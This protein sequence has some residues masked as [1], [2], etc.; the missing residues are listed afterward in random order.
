MASEENGSVLMIQANPTDAE[1]IGTF[2]EKVAGYQVT[3]AL[4]GPDFIRKL[5]I[6][7]SMI[8]IDTQ[9]NENFLRAIEI[10]RRIPKLKS[11]PIGVVTADPSRLARCDEKGIN[12]IILK[13]FTP[14]LLLAKIWKL[15]KLAPPPE[16]DNGKKGGDLNIQVDQIENLPTLPSVY[17]EVERLCQNPDVDSEELSKV[18]QTDPSITLKLLRLANSAFFGF[19]RKVNSVK[20]AISLLGN[21][22][23]K[24][25]VLSISIYEAT[26]GEEVSAGLDKKKFWQHS[27]G[28][29][30]IA[31]F[32]AN[33][34]GIQR[35]EVFAA[36]I[37]HDIGKVVLDGLFSD[38]YAPVLKAV[39]E[40]KISI[41]QAEQEE[42]GLPHTKIGQELG[43][44]WKIPE[45][46]IEGISHHHKPGGSDF[47][48]ELASLIH[49]ADILCRNAEMGSGGDDLVPLIDEFASEKLSVGPEKILEW[50][51]D[52][53]SELEKDR[54]FLSA[55]EDKKLN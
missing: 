6:S 17:S 19:T 12:G 48:P 26:K 8:L 9:M 54:T 24:N 47:D 23:V 37:L 21:Q 35:D 55:M 14:Q 44:A 25:A 28:V 49:V 10:M 42:I 11:I 38:Y 16:K 34:L 20:D 32:M 53:L 52:I 39:A 43:Q 50:E 1:F 36:G 18:I 51:T 2:I 41:F 30:S 29:G 13:P 22:T 15:M 31:R 33:K 46:F 5:R 45:S 27:V 4:D 7:P 3:Q 40:R